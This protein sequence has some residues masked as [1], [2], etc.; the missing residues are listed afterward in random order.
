MGVSRRQMQRVRKRV[1]REGQAGIVHGN[2]GRA[3]KHK[4]TKLV[5]DRVIA[6]RRG[7][8]DGFNDQHFTEKL[9]EVEGLEISRASVRRI[10][11]SSGIGAARG[12]RPPKHRRRRDRR[13]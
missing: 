6:L 7:P 10:L 12:R 3:R 4:T 11:R 2:A 5:R 9:V 13:L 1:R 8:Y